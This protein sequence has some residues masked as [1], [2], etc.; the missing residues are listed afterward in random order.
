MHRILTTLKVL[1][2]TSSFTLVS[3]SLLLGCR[4]RVQESSSA[5]TNSP[6]AIPTVPDVLNEPS[7]KAPPQ[8]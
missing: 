8:P 5:A 4:G 2:L 3:M 6:T 1:A 7:G